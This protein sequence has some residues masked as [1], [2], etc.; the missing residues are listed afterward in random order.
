L[1]LPSFPTRRSSDLD[2]L[3]RRTNVI[4]LLV[5]FEIILEFG[6]RRRDR[7]CEFRRAE[8]HIRQVKLRI[9]SLVFL[10]Y[11]FFRDRYARGYK[12]PQ[13]RKSTRLNSSHV[14]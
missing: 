2:L 1:Y 10:Q 4:G 14:K 13:D 8:E 9:A 6:L 5:L 3:L 7:F 12:G 11:F